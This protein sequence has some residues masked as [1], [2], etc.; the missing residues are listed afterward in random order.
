MLSRPSRWP[1][2]CSRWP[3]RPARARPRFGWPR[4]TATGRTA[5]ARVLPA[6]VGWLRGARRAA[7][8]RPGGSTGRWGRGARGVPARA[9]P[10]RRDRAAAATRRPSPTRSTG[11]PRSC[12]PART[13]P[14]RCGGRRPTRSRAR[15]VLGPAA[16]AAALGD[17]VAAAL[18]AE[19]ARPP[20]VARDLRQ[21]AAAWALAERHG[22]PLADL[23][24]G[25][26]ADL[27]WRLAHAGRVGAALAGPRATAAVLTGAAR[28]RHP[29]GRAGRRRAAAGA[30][31][32]GAGPVARGVRRRAGRG[33]RGLGTGHPALGG[34]AMTSEP[35]AALA[36]AAALLTRPGRPD[37][38]ACTTCS[39]ARPWRGRRPRRT[40]ASRPSG[41]GARR[42]RL[43]LLAWAL[44]GAAAGRLLAAGIGARASAGPPPARRTPAHA[45]DPVELAA[46]WAELAVCLEAGL[47]VAAAVA[48]AA[49]P[50]DGTTGRACGGSPACS[51]SAATRR[52]RGSV[53][54]GRPG[55][56]RLRPRRGPLGRHRR[57]PRPHRPRRSTR[58]REA[59]TDAAEARAQRAGVLIAAP[60]GLCFLPAFLVL[61]VVPVVIGLAG[62]VLAQW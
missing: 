24:A 26:H 28:A 34:A 2:Q 44:T 41:H 36:L 43:G 45:D 1:A 15:A 54:P 37:R 3:W 20:E 42:R 59:L 11:S 35:L 47:P 33:R 25:V 56:R 55:D 29:P 9:G 40:E 8:A 61:G 10:V 27:R 58:V 23:L 48:A 46:A 51:N 13:R 38:D 17:G 19:A 53:G 21:V 60:L 49:E 52:R 31:V 14:P 16:T 62:E 18:V 32:R 39:P 57:R 7:G 30:A 5:G 6:A 4:C 22:V 50:L 12:G